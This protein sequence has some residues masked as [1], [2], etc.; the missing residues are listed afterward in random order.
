MSVC[1]EIVV[2]HLDKVIARDSPDRIAADP[3]VV[4]AYFGADA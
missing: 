2:L 4:R 1:D 3:A